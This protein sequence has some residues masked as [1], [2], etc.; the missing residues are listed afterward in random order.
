MDLATALRWTT[1]RYPHRRAVGGSAPMSYAAWDERTERCAHALHELGAAEGSR[2]IFMLQGGEPLATLHLAAQKAR[3]TSLPLSTRIGMEELAYCIGDCDPALIAVDEH[4][5]DLVLGAL[6]M[7]EKPPPLVWAG[8]RDHAPAGVPSL[9]R[10]A[11][12][13]PST[14]VPA[15]P[16]S[17]DI[18]VMLYT[19]GTTGKPKGVPRTHSAEHYAA[20]AHLV[21]T[22]HGPGEAT[23]GVMPLFHTMGLRTL[24]ASVVSAGTWVPQARFDADEALELIVAEEVSSLYLVPT[25]YWTLMQG[26]RLG[27]APSVRNLAYAGA[28]MTPTLAR[29]LVDAVDPARFVNHYGSTEI[30]TFTIGP[31]NI[32]KPGCAGRAGLFSRIRLVDPD[33]GAS[34]DQIVADGERGQVIASLDSPEAFAGYWNRPDA[35]AKA[36]RDGWYYTNDLAVAD[37]DGDLWV[38]GRVDDMINSG[39]ENIYPEEIENALAACPDLQEVIVAATPHDKWGQAVTAFIVGRP[40][41]SS[42]TTLSKVEQFAREG[43]GLPSLKRPK[44]YVVVDQIPKSAVGKILRRRLAAGEFETLAD[45]EEGAPA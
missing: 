26:D 9:A 18:S 25:M 37:E 4:T 38:S 14:V 36:I 2:A 3:V 30:Y 45:T 33:P 31:E 1:E 22:G 11:E 24:L 21:Q 39:G 35:D 13:A 16:Q 29:R 10:V 19:S 20:L 15:R 28:S 40:E 5:H 17:D 7:V 8:H 23:L 12:R 44:R 41:D 43:S 34:P 32:A 6:E 27:E 42:E